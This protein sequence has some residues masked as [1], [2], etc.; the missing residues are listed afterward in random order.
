MF[1]T[2]VLLT[3]TTACLLLVISPGPDNLLAIGRGLSQ[4]K[5]AAIISGV[6]SGSGIL[7]HV[8]AAT[9]GL[10]L[11]IQTSELAFYVVKIIGATYLICL[12][13]KVLK[14]KSL[15]SLE[16]AKKQAMKSIFLTGFLSAALN[17][18]P[19]LFV[20]A[21]IPQFVNPELGSVSVQMLGYG[22]WFAFLT[23]LGFSLM[24]IFSSQLSIW[25]T[26]RPRLVTGLNVGAGVTFISSGA[27]VALMRQ[28]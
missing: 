18:K 14:S 4:G 27:A 26:R 7:F 10:T 19:G 9:M 23:A 12:G 28:R 22:A 3:F 20:L 5:L 13:I 1:P 25:L 16:P 24:G 2:D 21:F 15:F 11:L 6:S 8:L 17:P